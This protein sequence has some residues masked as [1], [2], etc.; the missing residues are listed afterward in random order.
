MIIASNNSRIDIIGRAGC[1]YQRT[2]CASD[3]G[4]VLIGWLSRGIRVANAS[5]IF[6][7]VQNIIQVICDVY[8]V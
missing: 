6:I 8:V 1:N 5:D 7:T 2:C 3:D 4:E